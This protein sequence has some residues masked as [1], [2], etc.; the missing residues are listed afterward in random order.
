MHKAPT[1]MGIKD[2]ARFLETIS[3]Y[4]KKCTSLKVLFVIN[5]IDEIDLEKESIEELVMDT[6]K[7]IENH[8]ILN[9]DIIPVSALAASLFKKVLKGVELTRRKY[10]E[11]MY[12][13]DLFKTS[14]IRMKSYSL[15]EDLPNQFEKIVL[16]ELE[17]TVGQL[18]AAIE[19]TGIIYLER[20]I[21]E[22]QILSN[23][24][25]RIQVRI[26]R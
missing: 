6:K 7:Y 9:P 8:G 18:M 15:T 5:K 24:D 22:E 13:Y 3:N 1:Q 12:C 23:K 26:Q 25:K 19:N 4:I 14:D 20:Y 16:N 17:I 11:F 10:K 21:Q 2:D